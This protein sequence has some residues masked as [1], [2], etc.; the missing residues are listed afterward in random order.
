MN[1]TLHRLVA[2]T[3][4]RALTRSNWIGPTST[5]R[6]SDYGDHPAM[7]AVANGA[8]PR[9]KSMNDTIRQTDKWGIGGKVHDPKDALDGTYY[10]VLRRSD[11]QAAVLRL[12]QSH[13][14]DIWLAL[15]ADGSAPIPYTWQTD[16]TGSAHL[17]RVYDPFLT[18]RV[19]AFLD[20]LAYEAQI[21]RETEGTAQLIE[22]HEVRLSSRRESPSA[23]APAHLVRSVL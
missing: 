22:D 14:E 10:A 5:R 19:Y 20:S 21:W 8:V 16:G 6:L 11:Y 23:A 18:H 12:P 9:A 7:K 3:L 4:W 1:P 13:R 15:R 17:I 2:N